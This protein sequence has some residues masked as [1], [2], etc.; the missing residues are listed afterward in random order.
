MKKIIKNNI[1]YNFTAVIKSDN[2]DRGALNEI[3]RANFNFYLILYPFT[4]LLY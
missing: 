4:C 1:T 3:K 2:T